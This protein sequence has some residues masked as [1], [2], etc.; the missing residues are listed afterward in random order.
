MLGPGPRVRAATGSEALDHQERE[1][2]GFAGQDRGTR[3]PCGPGEKHGVLKDGKENA[4]L[5]RTGERARGPTRHERIARSCGTG[6]RNSGPCGTG[7]RGSGALRDRRE[8]DAEPYGTGARGLG[9]L[10]DRREKRGVLRNRSEGLGGTAGQ[11]RETRSSAGQERGA[12]GPAEW[13]A[14]RSGVPSALGSH[15]FW[16]RP[17]KYNSEVL[18]PAFRRVRQPASP[19]LFFLFQEPRPLRRIRRPPTL[20]LTLGPPHLRVAGTGSLRPAPAADRPG[21]T[22][23]KDERPGPHETYRLLPPRNAGT[24]PHALGRGTFPNV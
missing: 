13:E 9:A 14:P 11:E 4:G 7:A 16:D 17:S 19:A 6:E 12:R 24:R 5:C 22:T 21:S 15:F 20:P 3:G 10:R 23:R 18:S 8:R 2:R 1:T